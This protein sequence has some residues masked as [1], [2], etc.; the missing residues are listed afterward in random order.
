MSSRAPY[1]VARRGILTQVSYA[2]V[3][4]CSHQGSLAGARTQLA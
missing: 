4:P 3:F 1:S 2:K